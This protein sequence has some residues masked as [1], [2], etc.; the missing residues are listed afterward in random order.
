M[1][2]MVS[3]SMGS[4][5]LSVISYQLSVISYQFSVISFQLSVFS[6]QLLVAGSGTNARRQ[7]WAPF[8]E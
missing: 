8:G 6:Y 2:F 3:W 4:Y 5:Q 1:L 7:E